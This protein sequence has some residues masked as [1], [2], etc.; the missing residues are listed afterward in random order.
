MEMSKKLNI[1]YV[2]YLNMKKG[3]SISKWTIQKMADFLDMTLKDA[4]DSYQQHDHLSFSQIRTYKECPHKYW[5]S[6]IEDLKAREQAE[7][8]TTG[9]NYHAEIEHLLKEENGLLTTA[10]IMQFMPSDDAKIRAMVYAFAKYILPELPTL[11]EVE[12]KREGN[13]GGVDILAY[14]DA[15]GTDNIPVEHK[16]TSDRIDEVYKDSLAW[17]DQI[18]LYAMLTG[19]TQVR[20]TAI[21]KPTIKLKQNET[22]E[23]YYKRCCEWYDDDPYTRT[24]TFLV[25]R[26]ANDIAEMIQDLS[27]LKNEIDNRKLWYRNPSACKIFGC[28]FKSICLNYVPGVETIGFEKR[29]RRSD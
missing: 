23:E 3:K 15:L 27:V 4:L 13:I 9:S 12:G 28:P 16:T 1:S 21:Q 26:S 11:K 8:L 2:T 17:D 19:Q 25:T 22:T 7:A 24:G 14:L 18:T 5:L 10:E 6:Y 29:T 20:Y